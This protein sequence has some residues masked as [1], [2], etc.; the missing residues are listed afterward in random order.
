[1]DV[2][3]LNQTGEGADGINDSEEVALFCDIDADAE[4]RLFTR[5]GLEQLLGD[6]VSLAQRA[7]RICAEMRNGHRIEEEVEGAQEES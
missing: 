2:R 3:C 5:N 7:L 6:G 4:V 1:M